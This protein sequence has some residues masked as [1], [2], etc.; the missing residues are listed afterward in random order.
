MKQSPREDDEI[1]TRIEVAMKY[2]PYVNEILY[3][4]AVGRE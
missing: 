2:L 3:E 4:R 1:A